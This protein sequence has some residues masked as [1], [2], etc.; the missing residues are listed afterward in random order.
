[1]F[2]EAQHLDTLWKLATNG[3]TGERYYRADKSVKLIVSE[4]SYDQEQQNGNLNNEHWAFCVGYAFRDALGL[5]Y[6]QRKKDK[7]PYMIWTQNPY[8]Y[9]KEGDLLTSKCGNYNLQ[10]KMSNAVRRVKESN[11]ID[12]GLV[13]FLIFKK[14][15]GGY[16][17]H[18]IKTMTQYEFLQTLIYGLPDAL[19]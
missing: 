4:V 10:V 13:D 5:S 9:F 12:Y 1:M 16:R 3:E 19:L 7:K 2:A 15:E 8:I 18:A 11:S 6:D 14:S 17:Y